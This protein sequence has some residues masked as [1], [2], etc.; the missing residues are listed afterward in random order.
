MIILKE[1]V[2]LDEENVD[3]GY[4]L[5]TDEYNIIIYKLGIYL[6]GKNQGEFSKTPIGY[7]STLEHTLQRIKDLEVRLRGLE[8][9]EGLVER[10]SAVMDEV[11]VNLK[12]VKITKGD[13]LI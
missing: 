3:Y 1:P 10:I 6:K 7:F 11:S 4:A 2:K 8:D 5:T 13:V 9:L 12:I